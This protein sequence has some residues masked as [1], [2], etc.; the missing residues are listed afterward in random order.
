[1]EKYYD[2]LI[3]STLFEN[4]SREELSTML[5]CLGAKVVDIAKGDPVFLEGDPAGFIGIVLEGSI[6]IVQEDYFGNRSIIHHSQ[7]GD[8][9]G[10]AFSFTGISAMPVS[11]YAVKNSRCMLLACRRMM[12][13]CSNACHFHNRL[14]K[15]LLQLVSRKNLL[16]NEKIRYMS[17]KTT[18]EKL[19]AYLADQAKNAGSGDFTI[20]F[21]R[22]SLA[23][24]LGVERSAMSAEISKLRKDG[25]LETTGSSFRLLSKSL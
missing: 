24:Y 1:M 19:L 22:Q 17:K 16:L 7:P 2:L 13:V 9:F 3:S 14:V 21:D 10:E 18:R 8:I 12:T 15:N 23:D 25:I 20:P 4:I 5:Q 6:Q 11:G